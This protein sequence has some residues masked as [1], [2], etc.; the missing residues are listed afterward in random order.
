MWKN[1]IYDKQYIGSAIDLSKRLEKYFS[2]AYMEN[3]L[4]RGHSHIY[5][6]LLKNG[7]SNFSL[8]ILEYCELEQ[9]IERED[10]YLCSLPHEY[11]ILPKAGSWLGHKHSDEAKTKISD[12]AKKIY[13][14]GRFKPGENHPNYGKT[15]DNETK[16]KISDALLGNTNG[17]NQPTSQVIEVTDIA[18]NTTISYDSIC[19]AARA[20][21]LPSHKTIT[22]Y[23]LRNQQKP[24]KG[25]YTFKKL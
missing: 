1:L 6:A 22:N 23:I 9:C 8:T 15:L 18:N 16:Q 4:N 14:S 17:K 5:R 25:R 7:Y 20:L 21:N 11:N 13:H 10:Y 12:A 3:E 2:T 24:Y 19:E